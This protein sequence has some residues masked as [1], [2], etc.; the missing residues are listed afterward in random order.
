[1]SATLVLIPVIRKLNVPTNREAIGVTVTQAMQEM[2]L[3]VKVL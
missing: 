2:E 3:I 1:M